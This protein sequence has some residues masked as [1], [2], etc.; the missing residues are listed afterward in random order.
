MSGL[1]P[2]LFIFPLLFTCVSF[3]YEHD[4]LKLKLTCEQIETISDKVQE[5]FVY[6]Q[7]WCHAE[8]YTTIL[9]LILCIM[10]HTRPNTVI[11]WLK[12]NHRLRITSL[13]SEFLL[14]LLSCKYW[15]FSTGVQ[16]PGCTWALLQRNT[17]YGAASP[18]FDFTP[19]KAWLS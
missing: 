15:H 8:H 1:H 12:P 10:K 2:S 7:F 4:D 18:C 3:F 9:R 11:I 13:F 17:S 19:Q 5:R 16:E 6:A 14:A